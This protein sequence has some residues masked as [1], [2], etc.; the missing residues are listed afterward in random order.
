MVG[1]NNGYSAAYFAKQDIYVVSPDYKLRDALCGWGYDD[2]YGVMFSNGEKFTNCEWKNKE[3]EDIKNY[4]AGKDNEKHNDK[5]KMTAF[6]NDADIRTILEKTGR[7]APAA[8]QKAFPSQEQQ[9]VNSPIVDTGQQ[10][11]LETTPAQLTPNEKANEKN[12]EGK[13]IR[14]LRLGRNLR[15]EQKGT[16]SEENIQNQTAERETKANIN[17]SQKLGKLWSKTSR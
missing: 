11:V 14:Y 7:S 4:I 15:L 9:N 3:W 1:A 17:I 16:Q 5:P 13:F 2:G 8:T 6:V 10:V 12:Q